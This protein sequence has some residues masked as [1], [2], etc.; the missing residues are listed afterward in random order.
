MRSE[1]DLLY[2]YASSMQSV[3]GFFLQSLKSARNYE[4]GYQSTWIE[5]IEANMYCKTADLLMKVRIPR[6]QVIPRIGVKIPTVF[7]IDLK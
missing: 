6:T 3:F 7:K 5:F 4:L 2:N 1:L